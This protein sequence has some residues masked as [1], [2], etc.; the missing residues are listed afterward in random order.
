MWRTNDK[1]P[2]LAAPLNSYI[3]RLQVL[4]RRDCSTGKFS[5]LGFPCETILVSG[6][7]LL[8]V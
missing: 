4:P 3:R 2:H 8:T 6:G 7:W 5:L 1:E